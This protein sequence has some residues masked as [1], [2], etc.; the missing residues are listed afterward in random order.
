MLLKSFEDRS[1]MFFVFFMGLAI[2]EDIVEVDDDA[3]IEEVSEN[4]IHESLKCGWRIAESERHDQ[5]FEVSVLGS[6]CCFWFISLAH[7]NLVIP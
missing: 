6:K 5:E 1:E 7:L 2:D 4:F 3:G